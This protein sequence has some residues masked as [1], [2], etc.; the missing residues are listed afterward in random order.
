MFGIPYTIGL[1]EYG[2]SVLDPI[3]TK[4][5]LHFTSTG[6]EIMYN[7]VVKT[8]AQHYPELK[9]N[10]LPLIFPTWEVAPKYKE[11]I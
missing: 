10:A 1:H 5:G 4:T 7:E 3:L 2:K 9:A 11:S 6:Y 8:I